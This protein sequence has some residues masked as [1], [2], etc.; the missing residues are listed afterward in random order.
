ML[1]AFSAYSNIMYGVYFR[2]P[3]TYFRTYIDEKGEL[4][5]EF[6]NDEPA[7]Y[8]YANGVLF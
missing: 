8:D 6:A 1:L 4:L 3:A 7:L 5:S 2:K